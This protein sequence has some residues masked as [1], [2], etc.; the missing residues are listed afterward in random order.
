MVNGRTAGF[1]SPARLARVQGERWSKQAAYVVKASPFYRRL[2][3]G[4]HPPRSLD[5][6]AYLPFTTKTVLRDNQ[7]ANCCERQ[8]R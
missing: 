6:V 8:C 1:L 3:D 4:R 2:W 5:A 7:P